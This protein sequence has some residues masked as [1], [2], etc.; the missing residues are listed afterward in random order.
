M[1][2]IARGFTLLEIL[3]VL[4]IVAIMSS[5]VVLNVSAPSYAKFTADANKIAAAM[6]ILC[7]QAV[8]TNSVIVCEVS[9]NALACKSYK[10]G[11]WTDLNLQN[12]IS[13]AWPTNMTIE[14]V[15]INGAT[16]KQGERLKFVATGVQA[17]IS[18]QITNGRYTTWIDGDLNGN[19]QVNN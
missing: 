15:F 13:W 4:A 11:N 9:P 2:I 5:V 14:Q 12:L 10:N 6:G 17:P 19:F 16:L 3:I 8:Y 7:D 1:R 18:L